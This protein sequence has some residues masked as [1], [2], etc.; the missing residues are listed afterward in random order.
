[1][2]VWSQLLCVPALADT[3]SDAKAYGLSQEACLT[4]R[5]GPGPRGSEPGWFGWPL[6]RGGRKGKKCQ[7]QWSGDRVA[8]P[9]SPLS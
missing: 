9:T 2:L 8:G 1:M 3:L 7:L 5:G 6:G 4:P